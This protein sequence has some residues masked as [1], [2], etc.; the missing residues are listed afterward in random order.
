MKALD[1]CPQVLLAQVMLLAL[2]LLLALMVAGC[3]RS[4][5]EAASPPAAGNGRPEPPRRVQRLGPKP[6]SILSE[7]LK[8]PFEIPN[9]GTLV[10]GVPEGVV[11]GNPLEAFQRLFVV[12]E[13]GALLVDDLAVLSGRVKIQTPAEALAFCRLKT[14]PVTYYLWGKGR[15]LSLEVVSRDQVNTGFCFGD[16]DKCASLKRLP[17][18]Y[19][20][21]VDSAADLRQHGIAAPSARATSEGFVVE[22]T[23][24]EGDPFELECDVVETREL[25]TRDGGYKLLSA[26]KRPAPKIPGVT[27]VIPAIY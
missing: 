27:W 11:P 12:Y 17:S 5:D 16:K 13:S 15:V 14:S 3:G 23:L 26:S 22:R 8:V 10:L 20:G 6:S 18:G 9:G 4:G 19:Y 24:L 1:S 21:V 7:Q 25:V 2:V